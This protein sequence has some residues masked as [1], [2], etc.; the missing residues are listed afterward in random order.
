MLF[1]DG[2]TIVSTSE[3]PAA[4]WS[5]QGCVFTSTLKILPLGHFDIIV[6]M[7]WLERFSPMKV[8][9][10]NKWM[11][12]PYRQSYVTLQ[13]ITA[14]HPRCSLVQLF[15]IS[16]E[17]SSSRDIAVIPEV[18]S[19]LDEFAALFA[20]PSELP[21]RRACDHRIPLVEGA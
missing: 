13:G 5:V 15:Q 11:T 4:E 1:A 3:L 8:H 2:G 6:G 18:R 16:D 7:D 20:T 14:E 21:P 19:V 10:G 17:A 9:W 12:I